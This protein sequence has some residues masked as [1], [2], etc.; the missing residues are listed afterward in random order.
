MG[1]AGYE[2]VLGATHRSLGVEL[3]FGNNLT[4][5][6]RP[7]RQIS[8]DDDG[9]GRNGEDQEKGSE[10]RGSGRTVGVRLDLK[11]DI[12]LLFCESL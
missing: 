12:S 4:L 5:T 1:E 6:H 10:V 9:R 11:L 8:I 3:D 7:L 2:F